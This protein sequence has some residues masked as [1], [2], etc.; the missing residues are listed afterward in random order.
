MSTLCRWCVHFMLEIPVGAERD[1][2][3]RRAHIALHLLS[4]GCL[5][6]RRYMGC[7]QLVFHI[8]EIV[9]QYLHHVPR[10][11][12]VQLD[13]YVSLECVNAG[14]P[15]VTT[16]PTGPAPRLTVKPFRSL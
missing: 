10:R 6:S 13:L 9:E 7:I 5:Q 8:T 15:R 11:I 2:L 4:Y 16:C 12:A 3:V 1:L 14:D